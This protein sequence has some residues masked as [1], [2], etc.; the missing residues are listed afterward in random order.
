MLLVCVC[1]LTLGVSTFFHIRSKRREA[2]KRYAVAFAQ[3]EAE[4]NGNGV[5]EY[6]DTYIINAVAQVADR[7]ST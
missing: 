2:V 1:I 5:H 6:E 4:W 7:S 3:W